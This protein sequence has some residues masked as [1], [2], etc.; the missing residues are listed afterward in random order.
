M[1]NMP[2]RLKL[3]VHASEAS[4]GRG[5]ANNSTRVSKGGRRTLRGTFLPRDVT[6]PSHQ[7]EQAVADESDC[8]GFAVSIRPASKYEYVR[9]LVD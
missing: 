3:Y 4:R 9:H 2:P 1:K 6:P 7:E 5:V 8:R